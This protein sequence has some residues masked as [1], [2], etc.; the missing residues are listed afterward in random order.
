[1]A[2]QI[3]GSSVSLNDLGSLQ[4]QDAQ[5]QSVPGSVHDLKFMTCPSRA[6]LINF[7]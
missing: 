4:G 7:S 6:R 3:G 5:E 2:Y 1:M